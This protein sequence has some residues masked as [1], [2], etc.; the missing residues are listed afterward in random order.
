MNQTQLE[1]VLFFVRRGLTITESCHKM[2]KIRTDFY[3][4][5]NKKLVNYVI[6]L[7]SEIKELS[8]VSGPARIK[9]LEETVEH[10]NSEV[11]DLFTH[12]SNKIDHYQGVTSNA[13]YSEN[14]RVIHI[15][16]EH[17]IN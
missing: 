7:S 11:L 2:N 13:G 14:D 9:V 4:S 16:A 1:L 5:D 6:R 10:L 12:L 8:R 17:Y 3:N 15:K